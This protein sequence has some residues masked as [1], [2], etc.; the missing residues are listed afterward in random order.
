MED[1]SSSKNENKDSIDDNTLDLI[2]VFNKINAIPSEY[3]NPDQLENFIT[4][5]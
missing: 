3:V 1:R 5:Y 4:K 2:D